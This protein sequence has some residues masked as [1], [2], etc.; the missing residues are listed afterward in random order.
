MAGS[1]QAPFKGP[2]HRG[3]EGL[4]DLSIDFPGSWGSSA[5]PGPAQGRRQQNP[6]PKRSFA[7]AQVD[8]GVTTPGTWSLPAG[9]LHMGEL[10]RA[11][12]DSKGHLQ[13]PW[14]GGCCL[15]R[16]TPLPQ[17]PSKCRGHRGAE[18]SVELVA[19]TRSLSRNGR[20][21]PQRQGKQDA[22]RIPARIDKALHSST[23]TLLSSN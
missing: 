11:Q 17:E 5:P 4:E 8:N 7:K 12:R 15:L 3:A 10:D 9:E 23:N 16:I 22:G 14:K 6:L 1:D 18:P 20:F 2:S 13:L 19:N 21:L